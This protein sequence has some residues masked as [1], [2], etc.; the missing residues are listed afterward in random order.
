MRRF[1]IAVVVLACAP[2]AFAQSTVNVTA[3]DSTTGARVTRVGDATN[4]A[5]RVSCIV[6]CSGGTLDVDD[7]TIA[8]GQTSGISFSLGNVW[9][10]ANWKR[11][12]IGAAGTPSAQVLTVQGIASMTAL[13]VD[14]SALT[15][16]VSA[17]SLPLPTGAATAAKQPALGTAGSASADVITVQGAAS[18]TAV[19]VDG[20]A[21]TQ[22]VSVTNGSTVVTEAATIT[23]NQASVALTNSVL[24]GFDGTTDSRLRSRAAIVGSSD[25]GLVTRPFLPS[26]G[27]NTMPAMDAAA[28]P[29]Y[30]VPTAATTGGSS[31]CYLTSAA[32]TNATNC[33]ASAGTVYAIRAINTTTTNYFLR[34]YNLAAAPTCSSATGFIETIPVTGASANGGGISAPNGAVGQDYPTGIGFCLTAGGS[35]TDNTAAAT[36]VYITILYK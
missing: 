1:L 28:R 10:G 16:P 35:S 27:T 15:Q 6:G 26:D 14:G 24:F 33:K 7:G 8:G 12:T 3:A 32:T 23:A 30:Q 19:K 25:V 20:S 9:D 13:K 5:F 18:M 2:P 4:K 22:P 34:M 29:G 11:F 17:A 21:V 36:G 31:T